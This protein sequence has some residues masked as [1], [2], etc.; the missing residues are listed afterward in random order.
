MIGCSWEEGVNVGW[1]GKWNSDRRNMDD[2]PSDYAVIQDIRP[3]NMPKERQHR[4]MMNK[5]IAV[6]TSRVQLQYVLVCPLSPIPH[7]EKG[8]Q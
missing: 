8:T 2:T 3:A 7:P 4:T 1:F 5:I 6:I